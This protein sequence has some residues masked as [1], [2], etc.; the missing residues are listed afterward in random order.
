MAGSSPFIFGM[1]LLLLGCATSLRIGRPDLPDVWYLDI[2]DDGQ[3][4]IFFSKKAEDFGRDAPAAQ[5]KPP[6]F[7]MHVHNAAGT[8]MRATAAAQGEIPLDGKH[9]HSGN[10]NLIE[11]TCNYENEKA[12]VNCSEK[13]RMM[14]DQGSTFTCTERP[15]EL[16]SDLCPSDLLYITIIRNPLKLM[17]STLLNN[18]FSLD[19]VMAL[20]KGE[21]PQMTFK[22]CL[23]EH[24]FQ[25]FDNFLTRSLNGYMVYALPYGGITEEHAD[26]AKQILS[27]FDMV[28]DIEH[29]DTDLP[30][31]YKLL[32]WDDSI[33]VHQAN[34]HQ[35]DFEFSA[36]AKKI[37]EEVNWADMQVYGHY[38]ASRR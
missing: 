30:V 14:K 38:L 12:V 20:R 22:G 35:Q 3:E 26:N 24:G 17:R 19:E 4:E 16:E 10:W 6:V 7:F 2:E 11:E 28:L 36:E 29:F 32:N 1:V 21:M 33:E 27:K 5:S 37:L 25:H 13:A 18:H 8:F 31:L 34:S 9:G 23:K 15:F